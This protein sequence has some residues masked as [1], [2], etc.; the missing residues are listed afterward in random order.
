MCWRPPWG[1]GGGVGAACYLWEILDPPLFM[2]LLIGTTTLLLNIDYVIIT[3]GWK[4][5]WDFNEEIKFS[6]GSIIPCEGGG[7]FPF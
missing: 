7:H 3:D 4:L 1:G 2:K 5:L 6:G